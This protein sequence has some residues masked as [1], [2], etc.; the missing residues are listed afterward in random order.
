MAA[1]CCVFLVPV[2]PHLCASV[3]HGTPTT[4]PPGRQRAPLAPAGTNLTD[5]K[6]LTPATPLATFFPQLPN[7]GTITIDQ[8]LSHHSGLHSFTSDPAY[9]G[10]LAQPKTQAELLAI[11][12]KTT[13]DFAPGT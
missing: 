4:Q 10:Y 5:E 12:E 7:A 8:L 13:P 1:G 6:K 2:A 9:P 3:W 11:I